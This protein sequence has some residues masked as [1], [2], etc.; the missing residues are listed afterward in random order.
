[1]PRFN[2][3][4]LSK[5]TRHAKPFCKKGEVSFLPI[6]FTESLNSQ[7]ITTHEAQK[8]ISTKSKAFISIYALL[9]SLSIS[10]VALHSLR[11]LSIK[12]DITLAL[13]F[14]KQSLLYAKSLKSLALMCLKRFDLKNCKRDSINFDSNTSGEYALNESKN[15]VI[16]DIMIYAKTLLSTHPLHH[17]TRFILSGYKG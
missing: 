15:K 2:K 11:T 1:M 9:L 10:L 4:R 3:L 7:K 17:S 12:K 14:Q 8:Q 16:I 6:N 13:L 5:N